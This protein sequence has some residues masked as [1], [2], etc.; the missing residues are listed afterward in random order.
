MKIDNIVNLWDRRQRGCGVVFVPFSVY[1]FT[2]YMTIEVM[3][4]RI[5][6]SFERD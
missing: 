5:N 2:G 6:I 1:I 4:F 3:N